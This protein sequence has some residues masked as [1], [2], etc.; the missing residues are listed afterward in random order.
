MLRY[1]DQDLLKRGLETLKRMSSETSL[2][3]TTRRSRSLVLYGW[4]LV[5][6]L[7]FVLLSAYRS[8]NGA[9]D[10]GH[11]PDILRCVGY[12]RNVHTENARM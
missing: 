7:V 5:I 6:V 11:R 4:I 9:Q 3:I 10:Q 2:A 8:G 12:G 1:K